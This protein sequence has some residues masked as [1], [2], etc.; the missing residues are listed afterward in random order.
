VIPYFRITPKENYSY[1]YLKVHSFG[2]YNRRAKKLLF[3]RKKNSM[4]LLLPLLLGFAFQA[5]QYARAPVTYNYY[6][7]Y[8]RSADIALRPGTDLS[9]NG[10]T[11]LQN[12]TQIGYYNLTLGKWGPGYVVNYTDAFHIVNRE[13]FAIKLIGFNFTS[14]ATGNNYLSIYIKNSTSAWIQ[15]WNGVSTTISTS[16]YIELGAAAS[17]GADG[18]TAYVKINI[19]IPSTGI[20]LSSGT[21]SLAYSGQIVAWFTSATF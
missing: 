13:V 3:G 14:G 10:L 9:P 5:T 18:G 11:L 20:G 1:L 12:S 17:Y 2:N 15:A 19:A 16:N 6:V 8:A 7:V 4:L 21:S